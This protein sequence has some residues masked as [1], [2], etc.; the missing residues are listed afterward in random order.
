MS[1]EVNTSTTSDAPGMDRAPRSSREGGVA[2]ILTILM[3]FLLA[4]LATS[5]ID[6]TMKDAQIVGAKKSSE[7]SLQMAEAGVADALDFL[8][9]T[10]NPVNVP[11]IGDNIDM[12]SY[13]G[14]GGTFASQGSYSS[15]TGA[16]GLESGSDISMV[17]LGEGCMTADPSHH[18]GVWNIQVQGSIGGGRSQSTIHVGALVCQCTDIRGC[19]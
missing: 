16:Y 14:F 1:N 8:Y 4:T 7:A 15:D 5:A 6:T 19:D 13:G 17:G 12:T 11:E 2:M 9:N 18:Y 3:L 10:Y